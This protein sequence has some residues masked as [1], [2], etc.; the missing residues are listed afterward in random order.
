L[1]KEGVTLDDTVFV[2]A[3]GACAHGGFALEGSSLIQVGNEVHEHKKRKEDRLS[4]SLSCQSQAFLITN[5]KNF[6]DDGIIFYPVASTPAYIHMEF[7]FCCHFLF[8]VL[9]LVSE[10][11]NMH[12]MRMIWLMVSDQ[13]LFHFAPLHCNWLYLNLFHNNTILHLHSLMLQLLS[14]SYFGKSISAE[15]AV[16]QERT[17]S[18]YSI[19]L[20]DR[21]VQLI[22][23]I[24]GSTLFTTD[25]ISFPTFLLWNMDNVV[26]AQRF[27]I[28]I[29]CYDFVDGRLIC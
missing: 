18:A 26:L 17:A 29:I 25:I 1:E 4:Y 2:A 27:Q 5:R 19:S 3:L 6:T 11:I 21:S 15:M 13:N 16:S 22:S 7:A 9:D 23:I 28:S 8:D 12:N 10:N 24:V 14:I 20:R